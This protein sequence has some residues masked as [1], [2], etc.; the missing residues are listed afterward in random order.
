MNQLA[1]N[2]KTA[3][4]NFPGQSRSHSRFGPRN[5][6]FR[7]GGMLALLVALYLAAPGELLACPNC[8]NAFRAGVDRAYAASILFMLG[9]PFAL[10]GAWGL[11]I[12][13]MLR[14]RA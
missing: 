8:K 4:K 5:W 1:N 11:A 2:G 10:L 6:N 7:L 14:R 12:L 13:R 9:M 3:M